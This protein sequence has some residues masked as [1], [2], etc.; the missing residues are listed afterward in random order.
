MA[1]ITWSDV[2]NFAANLST[3]D[4]GAQTD[5][6]AEVNTC[7]NVSYWGGESGPKLKLARIYLAAH[8]AT[9]ALQGAA[10]AGGPV[11]ME[12]VDRLQ[13]SYAQPGGGVAFDSLDSTAFGKMF[14][15]LA[16]TTKARAP[17]VI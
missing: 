12:M 16:R 13:V 17:V 2:D 10:G 6:L 1:S 15:A 7:L 9:C 8:M 5:I 11:T 14:R 4:A 3:V